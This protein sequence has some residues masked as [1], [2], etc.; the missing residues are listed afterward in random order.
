[1]QTSLE[2]FILVP[3]QTSSKMYDRLDKS[4]PTFYRGYSKIPLKMT[5][6]IE[7]LRLI[8]D[9]SCVKLEVTTFCGSSLT[10]IF[11]F[12]KKHRFSCVQDHM[13]TYLQHTCPL[14]LSSKGR[15]I[16]D[17]A[18]E[19]RVLVDVLFFILLFESSIKE[20]LV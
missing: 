15:A 11:R 19:R 5:H 2:N 7:E 10:S 14:E 3:P 8:T 12:L 1:M 4:R 6:R 13:L 9:T 16:V 18:T 20:V 17:N